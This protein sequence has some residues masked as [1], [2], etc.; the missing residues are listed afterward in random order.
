MKTI[1]IA[2]RLR[3]LGLSIALCIGL[4]LGAAIFASAYLRVGGP[5]Y[6]G[7]AQGKDLVADILPPPEY[8]I[9]AYLESTLIMQ[10]PK[11]VER[12]AA[13]LR[14]LH[15]QYDERRDVWKTSTLPQSL[16]LLLTRDSDTEV[17]TFWKSVEQEQIPAVRRGDA[18]AAEAAYDRVD[19]AYSRHRQ[20]I[21]RVVIEA[22]AFADQQVARANGLALLALAV[23]GV[24]A[25]VVTVV[26]FRALNQFGREVI[27]PVQQITAA[28]TALA[29]GDTA[30]DIGRSARND[31]IGAMTRAFEA[32]KFVSL[33]AEEG[34]AESERQRE[35][36]Q[37]AVREAA[38]H[39]LRDERRLVA[40]L[41]GQ[42]MA[43]L[44]RG[45]LTVR[46]TESLPP[47]YS[48]LGA[49]FNA[50]MASLSDSI[51]KV[52][53]AA[54][55]VSS[56][57][58]QITHSSMELSRNADSQAA[59][60]ETT[61]AS[62]NHITTNVH[63]GART[64]ASVAGA[65]SEVRVTASRSGEVMKEAVEAMDEI[66]ASSGQITRI[67]GV[68]DEIAFQT[69]LLALN[70]GVEAAR[71][72][73]AGRGF[74]VVA[75][76]VRALA[77]RSAQAAQEI[78]A[79]IASS[80]GRVDRGVELVSG[81]GQAMQ[82]IVSQ[83]ESVDALISQIARATQEQAHGLGQINQSVTDVDRNTQRNAAM[84]QEAT[85][86]AQSLLEN[87]QMLGQL[88]GMF[89]TG[90]DS[91]QSSEVSGARARAG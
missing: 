5:V 36:Q 90:R 3:R 69:N 59:S 78:K 44:A 13:R 87:A 56:G 14:E 49:D 61:A 20:V 86:A 79:L 73:D 32:L 45:D 1:M 51:Q 21:D 7:V 4:T 37:A 68:I 52:A 41:L 66:R 74:A 82:A 27:S 29:E 18:A 89:R 65:V 31:E 77:Q 58:N 75:M 15:K 8:V 23:I 17:Q 34:Q 53:G 64:A 2:T 12:R 46:L 57:A 42:G 16:K 50:A 54:H 70:A 9:E 28:M 30:V 85:A 24:A 63:D 26:L 55:G 19:T 72:G 83:I 22:N 80:A 40:E 39:A 88:V 91:D 81:T 10:Q 71:A 33:A 84:A 25:T 43:A 35:V 76:E 47:E 62:L 38:D 67:T 60:L 6:D 11:S 48:A